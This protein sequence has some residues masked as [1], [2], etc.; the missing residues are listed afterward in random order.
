V[1]VSM[2]VVLWVLCV[3]VGIAFDDRLAAWIN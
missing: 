2:F 1:D 3:G